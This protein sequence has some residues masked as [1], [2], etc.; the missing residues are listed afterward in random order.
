MLILSE[1][2]STESADLTESEQ[3]RG[4]HRPSPLS[5]RPERSA[6]EGPA[7]H[8]SLSEK[9]GPIQHGNNLLPAGSQFGSRM[10]QVFG[11]H[12]IPVV[13][14]GIAEP[15]QIKGLDQ[16]QYLL[17]ECPRIGSPCSLYARSSRSRDAGPKPRMLTA[18][19]IPGANSG[20]PS[21]CAVSEK[22][23]AAK[24][25]SDTA[26]K[27]AKLPMVAYSAPISRLAASKSAF[28]LLRIALQLPL[29]VS[30]IAMLAD[31]PRKSL[32]AHQ[33]KWKAGR[34]Q[35]VNKTRRRGQ[36]RPPLAGDGTGC[37]SSLLVCAGMAGRPRPA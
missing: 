13:T 3:S 21:R 1:C 29:E 2:G 31:D 36:H 16:P 4:M 15:T 14:R 27:A 28:R 33:G 7:V 6:V 20:L 18:R 22:L 12:G 10:Q 19:E 32:Y 9:A 30:R 25:K 11:A 5:S 8:S 37:E 24:Y 35:R 17:C 23:T 26:V 34:E